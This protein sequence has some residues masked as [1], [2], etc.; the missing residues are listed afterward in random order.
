M[1]EIRLGDQAKKVLPGSQ[2]SVHRWPRASRGMD[3]GIRWHEEKGVGEE[4]LFFM[5]MT[6]TTSTEQVSLE[7]LVEGC[8]VLE[9]WDVNF[10][11]PPLDSTGNAG[12]SEDRGNCGCAQHTTPVL[13]CRVWAT[14]A[15][16]FP[17]MTI[18]CADFVGV[19][20]LDTHTS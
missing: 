10:V 7:Q 18:Q 5:N 15:W 2:D 4:S 8:G 11:Q 17:R 13:H 3:G 9:V 1:S 12:R 6:I 16:I 20:S 19:S 14:R